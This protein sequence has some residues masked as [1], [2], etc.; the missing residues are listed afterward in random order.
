MPCSLK[1]SVIWQVS[2]SALASDHSN[3]HLLWV[4]A[5]IFCS[6]LLK[7]SFPTF[8]PSTLLHQT[9]IC[10]ESQAQLAPTLGGYTRLLS[11]TV[12][13]INS[14]ERLSTEIWGSKVR[15]REDPWRGEQNTC[16]QHPIP[17]TFSTWLTLFW[18]AEDC[19]TAVRKPVGKVKPDSQ[20]ITGG[21]A[22]LAHSSNCSTRIAKSL[23]HAA[24]GFCEGYA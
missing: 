20:K 22:R 17:I 5:P 16:P 10:L 21:R 4:M 2:K 11:S 24:S 1:S 14:Q 12:E 7:Q 13:T 6:S 3:Y 23:V 19:S 9:H 8:V 18:R 15:V